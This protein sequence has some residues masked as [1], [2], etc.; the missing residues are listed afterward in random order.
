[1]IKRIF[2][3]IIFFV[4]L[5]TYAQ[6]WPAIHSET[7]P[8][9]RWWWMGSAVDE[10]GI[11]KQ[12]QSLHHVGFGGVEI[13]PIYGAIGYEKKY[14]N[15]LSPQWMKMLDY[16]ISKSSSLKMGVDISVGTGWP[17][18]GPQVTAQDAATKQY[19]DNVAQG[20][21]PKASVV[22]ATAN[23]LTKNVGN[24]F[25]F[26]TGLMSGAKPSEANSAL[27]STTINS[28]ATE[29]PSYDKAITTAKFLTTVMYQTDGIANTAVSMGNFTSLLVNENLSNSYNIIVSDSATL[30]SCNIFYDSDAGRWTSNLNS[31]TANSIV[32]HIQTVI[33]LMEARR[34]HDTN[35]FN[36]S[37]QLAK[38]IQEMRKFTNSGQLEKTLYNTVGNDKIKS[39]YG[40]SS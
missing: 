26:F 27:L 11:D 3:S 31:N 39:Y 10:N 23:T 28:V 32:S 25:V 34:G 2:A 21:D 16:T 30:N 17:I 18:G 1:M 40:T 14:I 20:L 15:Y 38:E 5:Q 9:T 37:Q 24:S 12:L 22:Y 6:Q 13:V 4:S 35:F 8:W 29:Y 36:Q 7:K 19:V 33:D